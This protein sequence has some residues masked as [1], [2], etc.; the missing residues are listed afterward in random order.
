MGVA[1][2]ILVAAVIVLTAGLSFS[3]W[4]LMVPRRNVKK[5]KNERKS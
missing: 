2:W 4:L 1:F 5:L 3:V